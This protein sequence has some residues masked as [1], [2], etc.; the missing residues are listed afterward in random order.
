MKRSGARLV[1]PVF[2]ATAL[3]LT[4]VVMDVERATNSGEVGRG[5]ATSAPDARAYSVDSGDITLNE[6]LR[7][8]N[9]RL[10]ECLQEKLRF[11]T[12]GDGFG[13]HYKLYLRLDS[14]EACINSFLAANGM[15]GL[16]QAERIR[17]SGAERPLSF[18]SLWMDEDIV[19]DMGWQLGPEQR[20]QEFSVGKP[21][22]YSAHALV[23]H[24]PDSQNVVAYVYVFHGG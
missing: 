4:I 11:A 3:L 13:Y 15:R 21:N 12:A 22:L 2:V 17:G 20:F 24:V 10:P 9:L 6:G 16:L 23:Q 14:S 18:R 1:W 8:A 19:T 7:R 5:P